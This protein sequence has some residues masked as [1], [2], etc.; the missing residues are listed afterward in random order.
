VRIALIAPPWFA[1]PPRAHGGVETLLAVLAEALRDAGEDVVLYSIGASSPQ[2]EV[3]WLYAEEQEALLGTPQ[4]VGI[5][6][7]HALFAYTDIAGDRFDVV[8]DHSGYVGASIAALGARVPVLCTPHKP[9]SGIGRGVYAIA[10]ESPRL[11]FSAISDH[12][13]TQMDGLKVVAT[14]HNAVDLRAFPLVREKQDY[15]VD[16]SR[17]CP[18]KAPHRAIEV[19]RL[20]QLPLKLAGRIEKTS[21][22]RRYF[23]EWIE[24]QLGPGVEYLGEVAFPEKVELLARAR[25]LVFPVDWPEPFG[26]VVAEALACGTPVVA[27]PRGGIPE[28]VRDGVEGFLRE[29]VGPLADAVGK[30]EAVDPEACRRR[31]SE[32]FSPQVMAAGYRGAYET[33]L[34]GSQPEVPDA[35]DPVRRLQQ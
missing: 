21:D 27:T 9:V 32:R 34:K 5:E 8:H 12:Q 11:F 30:V 25:A 16:I 1:V 7:A 28:I 19:A 22:G 17:I 29:D 4:R 31:V 20:A 18:E 15:L 2:V 23:A 26:L 35:R 3:R 24:L 10:N 33:I 14:V 6:S 13:R